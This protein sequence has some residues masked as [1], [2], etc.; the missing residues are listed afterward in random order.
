MT[1]KDKAWQV[2]GGNKQTKTGTGDEVNTITRIC[3][4]LSNYV[5]VLDSEE[6]VIPP[7]GGAEQCYPTP[8]TEEVPLAEKGRTRTI[9]RMLKPNK[10]KLKTEL[11]EI[12]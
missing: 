4:G 7:V 6:S 1:R 5:P 9:G 10:L 8:F 11:V 2:N 3:P 12:F